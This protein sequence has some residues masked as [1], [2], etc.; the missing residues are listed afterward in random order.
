MTKVKEVEIAKEVKR[1]DSWRRFACGDVI[2]RCEKLLVYFCVVQL[3]FN[4]HFVE[5][6]FKKCSK[7]YS[8]IW[9]NNILHFVE[10]LFKFLWFPILHQI[11]NVRCSWRLHPALSQISTLKILWFFEKYCDFFEKILHPALS[12]ISTLENI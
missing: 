10:I 11:G 1:S 2:L 12:Q 9:R 3:F 8:V 7:L 6:M 4:F 5:I